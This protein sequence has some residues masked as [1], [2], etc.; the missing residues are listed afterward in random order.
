MRKQKVTSE[1]SWKSTT[2]ISVFIRQP[3]ICRRCCTKRVLYE[4]PFAGVHDYL[5]TT[6]PP[7]TVAN[8][9]KK[10]SQHGTRE[11][12]KSSNPAPPP[13]PPPTKRQR[14]PLPV[15]SSS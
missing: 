4:I 9:A 15:S 3:T 2:T 8:S 6:V 12:P 13:P 11:D 7:R 10:Y 1:S 5:T 14:L